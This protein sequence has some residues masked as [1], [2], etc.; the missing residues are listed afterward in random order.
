[1]RQ[2]CK[3]G[4]IFFLTKTGFLTINSIVYNYF[5]VEIVSVGQI[6]FIFEMFD[7]FYSTGLKSEKKKRNYKKIN[8]GKVTLLTSS[9]TIWT[10]PG[11][12]F[13]K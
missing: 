1:M 13:S 2:F 5:G 7:F 9:S 3:T 10:I 11:G 8:R 6:L 12:G 4:F